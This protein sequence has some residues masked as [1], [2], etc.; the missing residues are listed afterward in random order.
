MKKLSLKYK[1]FLFLVAVSGLPGAAPDR[2]E[3]VLV[4]FRRLRRGG[5]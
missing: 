5:K 1:L 4:A 3:F 2:A